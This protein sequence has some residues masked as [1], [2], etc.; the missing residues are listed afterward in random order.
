MSRFKEN[1]DI[2]EGNK[3]VVEE[4][5]QQQE[6]SHNESYDEDEYSSDDDYDYFDLSEHEEIEEEGERSQP[7]LEDAVYKQYLKE[8]RDEFYQKIIDKTL[9][10]EILSGLNMDAVLEIMLGDL[11]DEPIETQVAVCAHTPYTLQMIEHHSVQEPDYTPFH[12]E[13]VDPN[14]L[15]FAELNGLETVEHSKELLSKRS[16]KHGFLQINASPQ[17]A[18]ERL[19]E[20]PMRDRLQFFSVKGEHYLAAWPG[21]FIAPSNYAALQKRGCNWKGR[22]CVWLEDESDDSEEVD[23]KSF[24]VGGRDNNYKTSKHHKSNKSK[25]M[26]LK[27]THVTN[28]GNKQRVITNYNTVHS[29]FNPPWYQQVLN[30][31]FPRHKNFTKGL[32]PEK[33]PRGLKVGDKVKG[34][35][36]REILGDHIFEH[37]EDFRIQF[38]PGCKN[39]KGFCQTLSF[40]FLRVKPKCKLYERKGDLYLIGPNMIILN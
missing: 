15:K 22:Y 3:E 19:G 31:G 30:L 11:D 40:L 21:H 24:D 13:D 37:K 7:P 14:Y 25:H 12:E 28:D 27:F 5:Q 20:K 26:L 6:L 38:P 29:N 9:S 17:Q 18:K 35:N 2:P 39:Q 34:K 33:L 23:Y 16:E 36:L 1:D 32:K 8:A 10:Q 4:Q